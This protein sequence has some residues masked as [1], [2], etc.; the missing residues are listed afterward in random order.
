MNSV[1]QAKRQWEVVADSIPLLL[2]LVDRQGRL[3]RA[4][5]TL[6]R[7]QLGSVASIKGRRLHDILHPGCT[8]P[9]CP[10]AEFEHEAVLDL[11]SGQRSHMEGFDPRLGR[12]V[13]INVQPVIDAE[14][15]EPDGARAVISVDDVSEIRR[16]EK[17]VLCLQSSLRLCVV[18]EISKRMEMEEIQSRLLTI[19]SRTPSF[20]GMADAEGSLFYV[21]DSGRAMLGRSDDYTTPLTVEG[22]LAPEFR[23]AL[24]A[25][26][27]PT[28]LEKG[29]WTGQ[30][31]LLAN[32]GRRVPTTQ[33]V[34]AHRN[35]DGTPKGYS[36]VEEN[37]TAWVEAAAALRKSQEETQRLSAQLLEVQENERRRIAADLHDV[38]GQSLSLIKLA[39]D[40]AARM[41]AQGEGKAVGEALHHLGGKVKEALTEVQRVSMNLRPSTLDDLGILATLSWF[42]REFEATCRHIRVEKAFTVAEAS[43]PPPLKTT[44]FRI[45][46]EATANIVKHADAS[47]VRVGLTSADGALELTIEDNGIG[48][49]PASL[50][51]NGGRHG[52]GLRSMQE[53]TRLSGGS[54]ALEST[55][56][57]GT[58]I[59]AR[60]PLEPAPTALPE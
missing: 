28:A 11:A 18:Q 13:A 42:F 58:R 33:V 5:R 26:V 37:M 56:G 31:A 38:I 51:S 9:G 4:N 17:G 7:W 59:R 41:A 6:E 21:N 8:T 35:P 44:I 47:Q 29:V 57:Q 32:D 40:N 20:I 22:C 23:R 43:I 10:L 34:I 15:P 24:H 36:I 55:A 60:W 46:Q 52:L 12:H 2:C 50:A 16:A 3:I 45:L 48:F 30:S 1:E 14:E 19:L 54:Y 53:R 27:L 25:E 39:I 49:D